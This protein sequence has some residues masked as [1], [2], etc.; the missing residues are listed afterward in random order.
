MVSR[1]DATRRA[2]PARSQ[3]SVALVIVAP[4]S[5][6]RSLHE[7]AWASKLSVGFVLY[8]AGVMALYAFGALD[9]CGDAPSDKNDY[10]PF[11]SHYDD[12]DDPA[13]NDLL[14]PPPDNDGDGDGDGGGGDDGI[15]ATVARGVRAALCGDGVLVPVIFARSTLR[16]V[17][18]MVFAYTCHQNVL[19]VHRQRVLP[20]ASFVIYTSLAMQSEIIAD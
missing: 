19:Q 16:A 4:L 18:V 3:V 1:P 12:N 13:T 10:W 11:N 5:Y 20:Y 15:A 8:V 6:L 7:L 9:P 14:P 2:A 17:N